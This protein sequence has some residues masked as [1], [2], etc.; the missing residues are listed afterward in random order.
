M[1]RHVVTEPVAPPPLP[2]VLLQID[3]LP[4]LRGR[5]NSWITSCD[6]AGSTA[7]P[8]PC[9]ANCYLSL[10]FVLVLSDFVRP[11]CDT[12]TIALTALIFYAPVTLVAPVFV[13][14]PAFPSLLDSA[15]DLEPSLVNHDSTTG[16]IK[17]TVWPSL[18]SQM[19]LPNAVNRSA[20][21]E[22]L[23]LLFLTSKAHVVFILFNY[24]MHNESVSP[25]QHPNSADHHT[26]RW[27]SLV[28]GVFA[29]TLNLMA[30]PSA[31]LFDV[32]RVYGSLFETVV[33]N[34]QRSFPQPACSERSAYVPCFGLGLSCSNS[35]AEPACLLRTATVD[36]HSHI[37]SGLTRF[38]RE[39]I[40]PPSRPCI[41]CDV[42]RLMLTSVFAYP[43]SFP[44][45]ATNKFAVPVFLMLHRAVNSRSPPV[46]GALITPSLMLFVNWSFVDGITSDWSVDGTIYARQCYL[47]SCRRGY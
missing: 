16:L 2:P 42:L 23:P 10:K 45:S 30:E 28:S 41:S 5:G 14:D 19:T 20:A 46:T 22:Y 37:S 27:L 1:Q 18:L 43:A 35:L 25:P 29:L 4:S 40:T 24:F 31:L 26:S 9:P 6:D 44:I 38:G 11:A 39:D 15:A 36:R 3:L 8:S 7:L 12:D 34:V 47:L 13:I 21:P 33:S 17:Y 32:S